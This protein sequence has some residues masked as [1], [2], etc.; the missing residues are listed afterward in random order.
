MRTTTLCPGLSGF[1]TMTK[2]HTI[3]E[4]VS[5]MAVAVLHNKMSSYCQKSS[6]TPPTAERETTPKDGNGHD[7][8]N[9]DDGADK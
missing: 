7:D 2:I 1:S 3:L 8:D 4:V 5:R 6:T 9:N